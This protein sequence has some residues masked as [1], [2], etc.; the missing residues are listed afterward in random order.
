MQDNYTRTNKDFGKSTNIAFIPFSIE[1]TAVHFKSQMSS[2]SK[3]E[4]LPH[5][6]ITSKN[7][8]D[9]YINP[10]QISQAQTANECE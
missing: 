4:M 5:K 10:L 1:G 2:S 3:L 8:W 6:V 7:P 9:S